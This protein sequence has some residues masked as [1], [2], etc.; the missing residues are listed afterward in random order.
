MLEVRSSAAVALEVS[1][2]LPPSVREAIYK[3]RCSWLKNT[4][5]RRAGVN[6]TL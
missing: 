1:E 3:A 4:E 6:G 2:G 5:V